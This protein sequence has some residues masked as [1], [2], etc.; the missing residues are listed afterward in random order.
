N[1]AELQITA[2]KQIRASP[3]MVN[4][5]VRYE[6][7]GIPNNGGREQRIGYW[8]TQWIHAESGAWQI[9]QLEAT[10]ESISR[11]R[12]PVFVNIAS[13]A[14]ATVESYKAQMLRGN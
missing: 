11:A 12:G 6:F 1:T 8:K 2:I 4:A 3:L 13:Q 7:V 5:E 10:G 14:L 9:V